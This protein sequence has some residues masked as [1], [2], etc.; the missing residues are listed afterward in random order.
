LL[1][2][3]NKVLSLSAGEDEVMCLLLQTYVANILIAL[4]PYFDIPQ[5]YSSQTVKSYQNK[6]LGTMP[7]HVFA[8]GQTV[9]RYHCRDLLTCIFNIN[10]WI[11][12]SINQSINHNYFV[13]Y[14]LA[15]NISM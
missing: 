10:Q 2:W 13:T 4:N 1:T 7:P 15:F 6:S 8:I 9:T 11:N 14:L 12:Q 5:L 3:L